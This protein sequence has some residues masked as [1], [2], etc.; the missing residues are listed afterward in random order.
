M[1]NRIIVLSTIILA[2]LYFFGISSIEIPQLGD[3]LGPRA[4]PILVGIGLFLAAGMLILEMRFSRAP[5]SD[6]SEKESSSTK[7]SRWVI[8]AALIATALYFAAF[9]RIG[10]PVATCVYLIAMTAFFHRGH[11]MINIATSFLFSFGSY[12]MFT[13]LLGIQLPRGILP[14]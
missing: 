13:S 11:W 9:E 12:F 3:P 8:I 5:A 10:Y 7:Q 1:A 6:A 2:T 4:F 14:L